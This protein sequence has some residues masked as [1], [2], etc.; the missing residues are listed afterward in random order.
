MLLTHEDKRTIT[1]S[2]P[3]IVRCAQQEYPMPRDVVAQ[4]VDRVILEHNLVCRREEMS[5][6]VRYVFTVEGSGKAEICLIDQ[7]GGTLLTDLAEDAASFHVLSIVLTL[8]AQNC[9]HEREP[10]G[11]RYTLLSALTVSNGEE[12]RLSAPDPG[13]NRQDIVNHMRGMAKP[14]APPVLAHPRQEPAQ[15]ADALGVVPSDTAWS[16]IEDERDRRIATL[17]AKRMSSKEIAAEIGG[18]TPKLVDNRL[19]EIRKI[20]PE[21][22]GRKKPARKK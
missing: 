2:I 13:T 4:W 6:G 1:M 7:P 20:C 12:L 5:T 22:P 8:I 19:T 18:I 16:R 14:V 17:A 3:H 11:E 9:P 21:L 10:D 15:I